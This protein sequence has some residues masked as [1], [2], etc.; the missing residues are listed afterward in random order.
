M[1]PKT[2]KILSYEGFSKFMSREDPTV[3]NL[4][5]RYPLSLQVFLL[6][7]YLTFKHVV[8]GTR[9]SGML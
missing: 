9:I 8:D 4:I 5:D 3:R 7:E 6:I 1:P 2:K